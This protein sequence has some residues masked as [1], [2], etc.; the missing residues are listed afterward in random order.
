MLTSKLLEVLLIGKSARACR[1]VKF[2]HQRRLRF[3]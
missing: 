3:A 2:I 1:F